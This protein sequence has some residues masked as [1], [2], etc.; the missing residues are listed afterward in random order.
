MKKPD[1]VDLLFHYE[2]INL[3]NR[4]NRLLLGSFH[5]N[6]WQHVGRYEMLYL[7]YIF[8]NDLILK[9]SPRTDHSSVIEHCMYICLYIFNPS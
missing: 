9:M 2:N 5:F 8:L 1:L 3:N 6:V 7:N 4:L